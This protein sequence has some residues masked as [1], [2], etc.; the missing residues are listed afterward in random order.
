MYSVTPTMPLKSPSFMS[1]WPDWEKTPWLPTPT[2]T[3]PAEP[4]SSRLLVMM[5]TTPE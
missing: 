5:F 2:A 3:A 1:A 4:A